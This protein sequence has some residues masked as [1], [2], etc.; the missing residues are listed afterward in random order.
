MKDGRESY[1]K[2][3][4]YKNIC[5]NV[6]SRHALFIDI[7]VQLKQTVLYFYDNFYKIKRRRSLRALM[8]VD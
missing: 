5:G 6:C 7:W 8:Y 3:K 4:A 2:V 1:I